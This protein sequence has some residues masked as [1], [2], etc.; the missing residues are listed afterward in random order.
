MSG[1]DGVHIIELTKITNYLLSDAHPRG[2]AKAAFFTS[3][4]FSIDKPEQLMD[5]LEAHARVRPVMTTIEND[6]GTKREIRCQIATPDGRDP[7]IVA[8][9]L[10]PAGMAMHRLITA[11]PAS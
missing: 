4:G 6:Y 9:W 8:I 1:L 2:Q 5:A 3:F 11:Y 7:C 10:Q